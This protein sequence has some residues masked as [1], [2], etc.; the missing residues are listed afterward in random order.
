MD[1]SQ[2]DFYSEQTEA[3]CADNRRRFTQ[4]FGQNGVKYLIVLRIELQKEEY[5]RAYNLIS[6]NYRSVVLFS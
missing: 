2:S 1:Y 4:V 5:F 6:N 3:D